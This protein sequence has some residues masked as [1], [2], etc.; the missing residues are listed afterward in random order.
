[1]TWGAGWQ[2]KGFGAESWRQTQSLLLAH[3]LGGFPTRAK[4]LLPLPKMKIL[5]S[6]IP[7]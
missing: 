1:M 2:A 4:P 7:L 6:V 3:D 5:I